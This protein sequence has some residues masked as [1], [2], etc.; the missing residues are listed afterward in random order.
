[1][2]I[3]GLLVFLVFGFVQDHQDCNAGRSQKPAV[4]AN[5]SKNISVVGGEMK[6]DQL[7]DDVKLT[8]QVREEI[9][10]EKG[11]VSYQIITVVEKLKDLGAKYQ[12]DK[13]VDMNGRQIRF[14]RPPLRGASQGYEADQLQHAA[15]EKI[16]AELKAKYTVIIIYENPLKI[17]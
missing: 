2:K 10:D 16:L 13:L 7:P 11:D 12:A 9:R 4:G 8:D 14:Y 1:M 6:F 3:Y 17:A 5:M 15:D